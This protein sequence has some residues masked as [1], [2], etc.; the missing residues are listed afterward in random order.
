[1]ISQWKILMI[2]FHFVS[3]QGKW[4]AFFVYAHCLVI[5]FPCNLAFYYQCQKYMFLFSDI[6]QNR[7][8]SHNK[9]VASVSPFMLGEPQ[10]CLWRWWWDKTV[11]LP[12][13]CPLSWIFKVE[14]FSRINWLAVWWLKTTI[15]WLFT[16]SWVL[17]MTIS[18][19]MYKWEI[20]GLGK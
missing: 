18:M 4:R 19:C 13:L 11:S 12:Y 9:T 20:W 8:G 5:S 1:M 10:D 6:N 3:L 15:Y 7:T 2:H 16:I 14:F 17:F